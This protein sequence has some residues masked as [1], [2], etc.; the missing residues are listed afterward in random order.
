[1][2][3]Q[4]N[5]HLAKRKPSTRA[6][7]LPQGTFTTT[8]SKLLTDGRGLATIEGKPVM[9]A[10]TLPDEIIKFRFT[11]QTK[12]LFEG[13]MVEILTASP[14]R[15]TPKCAVFPTCGGC[16]LQHLD[17]D[18]QIDI[19]DQQLLDN[20]EQSLKKPPKNTAEPLVASHWGYRHRARVG[21]KWKKDEKRVAVGFRGQASSHIIPTDSC[22]I[23]APA[24]SALLPAIGELVATLH[25]PDSL[26]HVEMT[27]AETAD[28]QYQT[29]LTFRHVEALT[30]TDKSTL[31]AFAVS[32]HV[33]IYLQSGNSDTVK[34]LNHD[35]RLS[36]FLT[37]GDKPRLQM[38]FMP[39]HFT[40]VN[41]AMNPKMVAQALDW[42]DLQPHDSVLDLFCG[43]GNFTLP[44]AQ[45]AAKVVGVEGVKS[46]VDWAKQNAER[47]GINNVEFHQADLTQNTQMMR[48]R[49]K[50]H[51]N[52]VLI[53]PPRAGAADIM[54]LLHALKPDRIC[55]VSCH[56]ATLARD[57]KILVNDYGYQLKTVGAMDMFAQTAHVEA[58]A[59]LIKK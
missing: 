7:A 31:A 17:A 20:I 21:L 47:N 53:D 13:E 56:G 49:V 29:A 32:H 12:Q 37:I 24:L 35:Q 36:Y 54:P 45:R 26:T 41:F 39:F 16:V 59:L 58:M 2:K 5:K 44:M 10:G 40:Q 57:L 25:A 50:H 34:G 38:D 30:E 3:R 42:L 1:M 15:V 4:S 27:L 23:L 28:K 52:K 51:Y 9:I 6:K 55:Y 46:L 14:K 18:S 8:I 22:D 43:L 33:L 48:W 19:K 11:K